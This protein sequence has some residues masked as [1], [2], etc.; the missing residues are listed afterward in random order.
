MKESHQSGCQIHVYLV[1]QVSVKF[2]VVSAV[3]TVGQTIPEGNC[4]WVKKY[5]RA[6][7]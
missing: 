3:N 4:P 2:S 7:L 1:P 6:S 5:S